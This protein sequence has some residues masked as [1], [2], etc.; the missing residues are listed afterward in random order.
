MGNCQIRFELV[1]IIKQRRL[2]P[3]LDS[4]SKKHDFSIWEYA[5]LQMYEEC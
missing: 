3:V 1:H 5:V 2:N 4:C